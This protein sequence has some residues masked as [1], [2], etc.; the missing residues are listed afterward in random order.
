MARSRSRACRFSTTRCTRSQSRSRTGCAWRVLRVHR[1]R[2]HRHGG[3]RREPA[4]PAGPHLSQDRAE[5]HRGADLTVGGPASDVLRWRADHRAD[6][7]RQPVSQ[8]RARS[9]RMDD[10]SRIGARARRPDP[11][12]RAGDRSRAVFTGGASARSA[13]LLL[14]AG[15]IT[16]E[17]AP[18][19]GSGP[20]GLALPAFGGIAG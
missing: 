1:L 2:S 15:A 19:E 12:P 7:L 9:A 17:S 4:C 11:G 3:A 6:G 13:R 14:N 20:R 18:S 16:L 8:Y 10:G 5:H